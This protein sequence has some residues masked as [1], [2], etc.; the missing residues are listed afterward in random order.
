MC[1]DTEMGM[2]ERCRELTRSSGDDIAEITRRQRR[3]RDRE[4]RTVFVLNW[5]NEPNRSFSG[6]SRRTRP[7][8][9]FFLVGGVW[10][11]RRLYIN[12]LLLQY[13]FFLSWGLQHCNQTSILDEQTQTSKSTESTFCYIRYLESNVVF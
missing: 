8:R 12:I 5:F 6:T 7:K 13:S 11:G 10:Y 2:Q 3:Y 4:E 1:N 9:D